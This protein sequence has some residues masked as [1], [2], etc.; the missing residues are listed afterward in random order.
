MDFDTPEDSRELESNL[1][2]V[3]DLVNQGEHIAV[4][5]FA[6]VGRTGLFLALLA[7]RILNLNGQQAI[8][9]LRQYFRAVETPAQEQLV[10]DCQPPE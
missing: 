5:C 6:G 1:N 8:K 4:H 10:I 2:L 3:L 7:R 9:Y